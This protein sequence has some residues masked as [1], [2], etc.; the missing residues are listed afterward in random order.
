MMVH[1]SKSDALTSSQGEA[2][3]SSVGG[4]TLF[5]GFLQAR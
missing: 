2:G 1:S 5:L 4:E 3:S